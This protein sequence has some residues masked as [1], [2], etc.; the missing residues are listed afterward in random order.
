MD[1]DRILEIP[2]KKAVADGPDGRV[3]AALDG[4]G[5]SSVLLLLVVAVVVVVVVVVVV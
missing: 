1:K 2:L 5:T 4:P 3:L